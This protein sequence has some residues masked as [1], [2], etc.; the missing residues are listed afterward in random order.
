[1]IELVSPSNPHQDNSPGLLPHPLASITPETSLQTQGGNESLSRQYPSPLTLQPF[2]SIETLPDTSILVSPQTSIATARVLAENAKTLTKDNLA[3]VGSNESANLREEKPILTSLKNHC[4]REEAKNVRLSPL[5]D[6]KQDDTRETTST[7]NKEPIENRSLDLEADLDFDSDLDR[8]FDLNLDKKLEFDLQRQVDRDLAREINLNPDKKL[9]PYFDKNIDPNL[10]NKFNGDLDK[11]IR[12][13]LDEKLERINYLENDGITRKRI[14]RKYIYQFLNTKLESRFSRKF[15]EN[16]DVDR[17]SIN[18]IEKSVFGGENDI[19]V[20]LDNPDYLKSNLLVSEDYSRGIQS[21]FDFKLEEVSFR[22][23]VS[24]T[25]VKETSSRSLVYEID[26]KQK[27]FEPSF[28]S[29]IRVD[30]DRD[31]KNSAPL[32]DEH[33]G[34]PD[35]LLQPD[36]LLQ[37]VTNELSTHFFGYFLGIKVQNLVFYLNQVN[38]GARSQSEQCQTPPVKSLIEKMKESGKSGG[39]S[40][41]EELIVGLMEN[42]YPEE[43]QLQ[44]LVFSWFQSKDF[45]SKT[46]KY[47][48]TDFRGLVLA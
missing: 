23:T 37:T 35:N 4:D 15:Y 14:F 48:Q 16:E 33:G 18:L 40:S 9:D 7:S 11:E 45:N 5:G 43:I 44:V 34:Y 36:W 29:E 6:R 22:P 39:G 2:T 42:M 28:I 12:I 20:R 38:F 26:L 24:L 30:I 10:E 8:N 13:N 3:P 27:G 46:K 41:Y 19:R 17:S 1:M 47:R 25:S 21:V 31:P 32:T